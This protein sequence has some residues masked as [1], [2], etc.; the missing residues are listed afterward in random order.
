MRR[1]LEF[2]ALRIMW[3]V[4]LFIQMVHLGRG[5]R[6]FWGWWEEILKKMINDDNEMS[7]AHPL[8]L[9]NGLFCIDGS[10]AQQRSSRHQ[11]ESHQHVM[12]IETR[13]RWDWSGGMCGSE[14]KSLKS[15]M[16]L[17]ALGVAANG[18]YTI[19]SMESL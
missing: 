18:G 14:N 15:A 6:T 7:M 13:S 4:V 17:V 1:K 19:E 5:T 9:S 16:A 12:L 2:L 11:F 3:I 8:E 10:K